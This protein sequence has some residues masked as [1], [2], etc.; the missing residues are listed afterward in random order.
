MSAKSLKAIQAKWYEIGWLTVEDRQ[1]E[2]IDSFGQPLTDERID[3]SGGWETEEIANAQ[4]LDNVTV[5]RLTDGVPHAVNM[6]P[7]EVIASVQKNLDRMLAY[8]EGDGANLDIVEYSERDPSGNKDANGEPREVKRCIKGLDAAKRI[9]ALVAKRN[10]PASIKHVGVTCNRRGFKIPFGVLAYV[11][12]AG[13]EPL[14]EPKI[15]DDGKPVMEGGK[16]V[17]VPVVD[18]DG[19]TLKVRHAASDVDF[20]VPIHV[21]TYADELDMRLELWAE[22]DSAKKKEGYTLAG[23]VERCLFLYRHRGASEAECGRQ[24]GLTNERST[25]QKAYAIARLV[26]VFPALQILSRG[27]MTPTKK[28]T[29]EGFNYVVGGPVPLAGLSASGCRL[30]LGNR[31]NR[32]GK[33]DPIALK[34]FGITDSEKIPLV[35]RH[36]VVTGATESV[37]QWSEGQ[38]ATDVQVEEYLRLIIE[39]ERPQRMLASSDVDNLK[40]KLVGDAMSNPAAALLSAVTSGDKEVAAASI[41]RINEREAVVAK[42]TGKVA[43]LEAALAAYKE[44]YAALQDR[45]NALAD[46]RDALRADYDKVRAEADA[47][48]TERD[49]LKEQVIELTA[50]RDALKEQVAHAMQP[51]GKRG[52]NS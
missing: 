19:T 38:K 3:F 25:L 35:D 46:E 8:L 5:D 21:K 17:M 2:R 20:L 44:Q 11:D 43:E 45:T 33:A 15:G 27:R 9:R 1:P 7:E 14:T 40:T 22:N 13:V 4:P 24:F 52:K 26:E 51:A 42:A 6:T 37:P 31:L 41:A 29:G 18:S 48:A 32:G 16:P 10:F 23:Q 12:R 49:A 50:E 47:L 28:A 30:L 36:N 34:A 39:G